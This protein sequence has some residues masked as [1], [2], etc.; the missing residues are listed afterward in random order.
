MVEY[1]FATQNAWVRFLLGS[2]FSFFPL[3]GSTLPMFVFLNALAFKLTMF[4]LAVLG[5]NCQ[6]P[7]AHTCAPWPVVNGYVPHVSGGK[8]LTTY[9]TEFSRY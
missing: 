6:S 8:G 3:V 7:V 9:A 1:L 5:I 4:V 2:E